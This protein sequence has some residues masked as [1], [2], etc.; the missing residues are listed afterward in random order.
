MEM[1]HA[2]FDAEYV[3]RILRKLTSYGPVKNQ[4]KRVHRERSF[5]RPHVRNPLVAAEGHAGL[6]ERKAVSATH[7]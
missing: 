3:Y 2:N 6:T 1:V 7:F 4:M 5:K